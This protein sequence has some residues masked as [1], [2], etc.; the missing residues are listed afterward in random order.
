METDMTRRTLLVLAAAPLARGF[1]EGN[2]LKGW[3]KYGNGIWSVEDGAIVGRSDPQKPG[4]GYLFT[5]REFGDFRLDVEFWVSKGG[6]SGIFIRQPLRPFGTKGNERPAHQPE[7]GVEV[8]ID[9]NDPKNLTGAIYNRKRP[10]TLRGAENRWNRFRIECRG[11]RVQ[12]W[13]DGEIVNDYAPL[14]QVRG[15]IGLQIHGQEPHN[16]VIRF[17]NIRTTEL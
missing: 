17:R 12:V 6:N 14:P 9:Y 11:L 4:P 10:S 15:A 5:D 1:A 2:D 16:H 7:D 13:L 3:K 8:Q